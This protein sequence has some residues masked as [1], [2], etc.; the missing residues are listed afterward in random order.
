MLNWAQLTD[1]LRFRLWAQCAQLAT[2]L[3]TVISTPQNKSITAA[4]SFHGEIPTW[5]HNLRTFGEIGIV[6]DA[7]P[8][9]IRCKLSDRGHP[10]MFVEYTNNHASNVYQFL[11][12]G[13]LSL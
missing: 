9:K 13:K 10:C 12:L 1:T 11:T 7:R 2:K 3:E 6:H 4:E 8:G 5:T